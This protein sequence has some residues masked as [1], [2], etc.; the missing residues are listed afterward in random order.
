MTKF[1]VTSSGLNLRSTPE[2]NSNNILTVLS[3]GQFVTRIGNEPDVERF[4]NLRTEDG[5]KGFASKSFL[6]ALKIEEKVLW[7]VNYPTT[8]TPFGLD[9]FVERAV[10]IGATAVAIRTDNDLEA[11]IAA[12]HPLGIK[13]YG[14][15][16]P[17]AE[18]VRALEEAN[19][20]VNLYARGLDGYYVD[21]EGDKGKHYD[22]DRLNLAPIA[23]EFCKIITTA[24]PNKPFGT[25]SHFRGKKVHSKLPWETFFQYSTLLLPQAYWKSADGLIFGGDPKKN[26][27]ISLDEWSVIGAS[28]DK[29]VP[30]AGELAFSTVKNINDYVEEAIKQGKNELHFYTATKNVSDAVWNAVKQ[31]G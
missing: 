6:E 11:A 8:G 13:V 24:A 16:W 14:W 25:T 18:R 29:I 30:M 7:V 9:W 27:D 28:K 20:V 5:I 3:K 22:W 23:D 31:I 26:Y 10:F 4:W 12:F 21:P 15:R 1:K 19:R 2:I 17:S